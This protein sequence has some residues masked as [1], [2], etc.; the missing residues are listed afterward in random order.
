VNFF[1]SLLVL[2]LGLACVQS[3]S[4]G[5]KRK[6]PSVKLSPA[7]AEKLLF[8]LCTGLS[9]GAETCFIGFSMARRSLRHAQ[10]FPCYH[11]Q[12]GMLI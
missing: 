3:D 7:V 9:A 1:F 5:Q 8:F 12:L 11:R 4:L 2:A 6:I 10:N